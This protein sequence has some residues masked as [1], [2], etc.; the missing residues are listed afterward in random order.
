MKRRVMKFPYV[1][2]AKTIPASRVRCDEAM[3]ARI[4]SS[5]DPGGLGPGDDAKHTIVIVN[6]WTRAVEANVRTT[7]T[8]GLIDYR[9]HVPWHDGPLIVSPSKPKTATALV[10]LPEETA[11]DHLPATG[12]IDAEITMRFCDPYSELEGPIRFSHELRLVVP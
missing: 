5:V 1:F 8:G 7:C 10:E 11:S 2:R 4:R 3:T 12:Y 9:G 6:R